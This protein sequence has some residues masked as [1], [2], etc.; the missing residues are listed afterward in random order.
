MSSSAASCCAEATVAS[1]RTVCA[2]INP[3]VVTKLA[4]RGSF[5]AIGIVTDVGLFVEQLADEL[6][7]SAG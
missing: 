3:A 1:V 2:D 7:D 4:D 5:Q 6:D